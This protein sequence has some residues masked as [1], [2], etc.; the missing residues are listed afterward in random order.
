MRT[1]CF[2][3]LQMDGWMDDWPLYVF[4][5]SI[6]VIMYQ[7]D[8]LVTLKGYVQWAQFTIEKIPRLKRSPNSGPTTTKAM[9]EG[10]DPIKHVKPCPSTQVIYY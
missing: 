9:G 6:L 1:K 5:H 8:R 10:L 2:E 3:P 7:D 4:F